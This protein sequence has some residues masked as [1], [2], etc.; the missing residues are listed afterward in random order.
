MILFKFKWA[1]IYE[2]AGK[3]DYWDNNCY[4]NGLKINFHIY[5]PNICNY[6]NVLI[7][8]KEE[9]LVEHNGQRKNLLTRINYYGR[10]GFLFLT[11][12]SN[13]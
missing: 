11:K 5:K 13:E 6:W 9:F 12:N 10:H 4:Y 7:W 1:Y 8:G 2:K 3:E